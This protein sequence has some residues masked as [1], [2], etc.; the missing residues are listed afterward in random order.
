MAT[1]AKLGLGTLLQRGDAG[2]P[3]V[4]TTVGEVKNITGPS[5]S[6]NMVDATSMDS[7]YEE[8][9]A[10]IPS[11]GTVTLACLLV[12]QNGQ[13]TGLQADFDAGTLRN[14]KIILNNH[15]VLGNRSTRSF[16]AF[17]QEIGEEYPF[18]NVM[19]RNVTLKISGAVTKTY[20]P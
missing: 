1:K 4:F 13:Q 18:D 15:A 20:A 10:G 12:D 11:G 17:V 16:A 7:T 9:V 5:V 19:V 2:S 8:A 6:R 14:F 3:E